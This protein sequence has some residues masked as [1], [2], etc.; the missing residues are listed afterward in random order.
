[1]EKFN[2]RK[3]N[4][5]FRAKDES[6]LYPICGKFNATDRAIRSARKFRRANGELKELEYITFLEHEISRI[7]NKF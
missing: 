7:V 6:H 2:I 4:K 3:I 5:A 1:M